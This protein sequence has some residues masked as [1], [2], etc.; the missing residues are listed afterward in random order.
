MNRPLSPHLSVYRMF[1][2]TMFTSFANRVTG[3]VLSVGLLVLVYWLMAVAS[4]AAAY[5]RAVGILSLPIFKLFY[6]LVLLAFSYHLV[7]GL[8]H[9]IWDTGHGL[10]RN[11]S[12]RSAWIV[13]G[14]SVLLMIAFLYWAFCPGAHQS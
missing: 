7:A 4:G 2:Y 14:V 3:A 9:L 6:V 1:R 12:K 11:Q 10:E 13:G 5:A 8:R